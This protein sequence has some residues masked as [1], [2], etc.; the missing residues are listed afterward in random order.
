MKII[1]VLGIDTSCDNTAISILNSKKIVKFTFNKNQDAYL[2]KFG[3]IEPKLCS[4]LHLLHLN[5]LIKNQTFINELNSLDFI[6]ITFGPGLITSLPIGVSF[7]MS[8]S[9]FFNKKVFIS[10][11]L[12]AHM[13]SPRFEHDSL[14]Y[15]YINFLMSGGHCII[16]EVFSPLNIKIL[17]KTLDDSPGEIIDKIS[18]KL[19]IN[20]PNGIMMEK[21]AFGGSLDKRFM[22]RIKNDN[23]MNLSFSGIKSHFIRKIDEYKYNSNISDICYTLQTCISYVFRNRIRNI[24]RFTNVRDITFSGGVASNR[25]IFES[26]SDECNKLGLNCY[27]TRPEIAAD[28]AEMVAWLCLESVKLEGLHIFKNFDVFPSGNF[29]FKIGYLAQ[30]G[31][32]SDF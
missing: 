30:S 18:Y 19:G 24:V 10:N 11:H 23:N 21:K 26:I 14:L 9:N 7:G 22:P 6:S 15:P 4:N 17:G 20:P 12:V 31:R 13:I 2:S 27:F 28:N 3:G 1:N 5:E 25:F 8:L 16:S 32:A 29:D